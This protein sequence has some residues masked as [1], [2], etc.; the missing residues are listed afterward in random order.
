MRVTS[1]MSLRMTMRNLS[2]SLERLQ[3]SQ[4]RLSSGKAIERVSDDPRAATDVLVLRGRIARHDQ[5]DRTADD[6]R[7]RLAVADQTLLGVSDS[8]IRAKELAVQASNTGVSDSESRSALAAEVRSLRS[9]LLS[10]ANTEYLGRSIFG[11]TAAGPAYDAGT[12]AL[13]GNSTVESRTVAEGVR[14]ASNITGV[15]AF[16]DPT[17]GT[18]DVFAVLDRLATAIESNDSAAITSEHAN[19]DQSR[20]RIGSA[21]AEVG[22]RSAQLIDLGERSAI[23]RGQLVE[24]L[25][26]IEDVDLAE[27][28]IDVTT[29][30]TAHQAALAAAARAMPPSLAQYLR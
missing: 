20:L 9:Q 24:R 15:Q 22:Q 26:T 7:A 8:M 2:S 11:G 14:V 12:G 10:D 18:G 6:T 25:S 27:A 29:F 19:L 1:S 4:R 30:D 3:G 23:R 17:S 5:M 28:V 16:G 21:L 13:N